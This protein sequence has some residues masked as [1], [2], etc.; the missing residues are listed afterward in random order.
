[1]EMDLI[2]LI[3]YAL[4]FIIQLILLFCAVKK[5]EK[6]LWGKLFVLELLSA[7]GAM[8]LMFLFDALPGS[9]MMP[10]LTW[11]AEVF[12]SLFAAIGY[13]ALFLVSLVVRIVQS[14]R[15]K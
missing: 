10:G 5:P 2:M 15:Q 6:K 11:F 3:A 14:A 7:L 8:G 13:G 12:Y 1:M 4:L 9:G